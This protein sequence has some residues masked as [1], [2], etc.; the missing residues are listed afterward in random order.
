MELRRKARA[1][2]GML[3]LFGETIV[4]FERAWYG[5]HDVSAEDADRFRLR[6][7]TMKAAA[8]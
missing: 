2:P 6:I 4:D 7:Q 3:P 5:M 1:F 8:A